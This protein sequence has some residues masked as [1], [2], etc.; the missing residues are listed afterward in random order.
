MSAVQGLGAVPVPVDWSEVPTALA[1]GQVAGQEN[2]VNVVLSSK[3][4]EKQSHMMLTS[5]IMNAQLIVI[6][7]KSWQALS[8]AQRDQVSKAADEVRRKATD[9]VA[10][11]E[12]AELEKLKVLKMNVIGPANGLKLDL[13]KASVNKVV[14]EKFG[15]KFG[16]LYRDIAAVK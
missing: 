12:S 6:N 11:D 15:T 14:Q 9:M 2:P 8:P 16:D 3:L 5:H 1:T 4:Y 7:E 13:F 10:S